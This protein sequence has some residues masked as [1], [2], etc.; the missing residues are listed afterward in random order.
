MMNLHTV[1]KTASI[2]EFNLP[3]YIRSIPRHYTILVSVPK[4][5]KKFDTQL[6]VS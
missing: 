6:C 5:D 1:F 4:T 2:L 3:K